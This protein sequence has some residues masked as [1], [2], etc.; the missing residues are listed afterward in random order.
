MESHLIAEHRMLADAAA[1]V[2]GNQMELMEKLLQTKTGASTQYYENKMPE[3]GTLTPLKEVAIHVP[4]QG[5]LTHEKEAAIHIPEQ[6]A[7]TQE[8]EDIMHIPEQGTSIQEKEDTIPEH[9]SSTQAKR[10]T[11]PKKIEKIAKSY[12]C[13]FNQLQCKFTTSVRWQLNKHM[14]AAHIKNRKSP[15]DQIANSQ[16][17]EMQN[18]ILEKEG[19]RIIK[20]ETS[21][22]E[23]IVV[24]ESS[25]PG[26]ENTAQEE[27]RAG[28]KDNGCSNC[29]RDSDKCEKWHAYKCKAKGCDYVGNRQQH[30]NN[31]V[32]AVHEKKRDY[33]CQYQGCPYK[34]SDASNF[35]RHLKGNHGDKRD[36]R[37]QCHVCP[38]GYGTIQKRDLRRHE[39]TAKHKFHAKEAL[40]QNMHRSAAQHDYQITQLQTPEGQTFTL[41]QNEQG[42]LNLIP[43]T[44]YI[45]VQ[46]LDA[47]AADDNMVIVQANE[48]T[49]NQDMT[50][51]N[52]VNQ[53][54]A[55][56]DLAN[57]NV[58][59]Q[60]VANQN[61]ENQIIESHDVLAIAIQE[62]LTTHVNELQ[63]KSEAEQPTDS[64]LTPP[65]SSSGSPTRQV[66]PSSDKLKESQEL[67]SILDDDE[68]IELFQTAVQQS[69]DT[70]SNSLVTP[71][72][73]HNEDVVYS[74]KDTHDSLTTPAPMDSM[75][76]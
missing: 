41:V 22:T 36:F 73:S 20:I 32:K 46:T 63:Q 64:P 58:A 31:H 19:K 69:N 27:A 66:A 12:Q 45:Q 3:Q 30:F 37:F 38:G 44:E 55:S 13:L 2:E 26:N 51:P 5:T 40:K 39:R 61:M 56:Q 42:Q 14:R 76:F 67:Q 10:D 34:S 11:I 75:E 57:S 74:M 9:G 24:K 15:L 43:A 54:V 1:L 68:F 52:M 35:K 48:D 65:T 62:F 7:L 47:N 29:R 25:T 28:L 33:I 8:R 21:K 72:V 16:Y 53:D 17:R 59:N 18:E 71:P 70:P 23:N 49:A 6:G 4:E 60:D 50:N